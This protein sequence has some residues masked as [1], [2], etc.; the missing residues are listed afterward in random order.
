MNC[1]CCG[2]PLKTENDNGWHKACIKRFFG[3][4]HIPEIE[5]DEKTLESLAA[6]STSKGLTVPG[7][8]KKL[9]LHLSTDNHKP[10]LTLVNYPTGY[11]LKPQVK[12]FECLPEAEQLVM[13]PA[14]AVKVTNEKPV[15]GWKRKPVDI[16][17]GTAYNTDVST[18]PGA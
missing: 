5:I 16:L 12:E 2:K 9:S 11:I 6:Q 15:V 13:T 18:N 14:D 17:V 10:R 8:Q 3:T 1:F 7:V 4:A